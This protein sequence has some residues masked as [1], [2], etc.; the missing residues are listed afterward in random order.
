MLAAK[1]EATE[2]PLTEES[3]PVSTIGNNEIDALVGF[4]RTLNDRPVRDLELWSS[5]LYLRQ[6]E[7]NEGNLISFLRYL[8]PQ[9]PVEEIRRCI[10]AAENLL[11]LSFSRVRDPQSGGLPP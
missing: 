1:S 2:S 10:K 7:R 8:K 11:T 9:Y 4:L 5:I 3:D 6:S